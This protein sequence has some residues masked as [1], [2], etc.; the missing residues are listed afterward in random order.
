[1]ST[2]GVEDQRR[3]CSGRVSPEGTG[4]IGSTVGR[5]VQG[6]LVRGNGRLSS[7]RGLRLS[8]PHTPDSPRDL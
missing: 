1:M 2:E 7:P 4:R 8:L 3:V 6:T 5:G